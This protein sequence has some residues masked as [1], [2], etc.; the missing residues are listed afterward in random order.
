VVRPFEP[1]TTVQYRAY[2]F[3]TRM[4]QA[5]RNSLLQ[6]ARTTLQGLVNQ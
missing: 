1:H 3:N 4:P 2:W 6:R 5:E